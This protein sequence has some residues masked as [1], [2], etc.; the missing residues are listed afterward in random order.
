MLRPGRCLT[1]EPLQAD[2]DGWVHIDVP[3]DAE[4]A[5]IE[6]APSEVPVRDPYP[7]RAH[8]YLDLGNLGEQDRARRRLFNLG[9]SW[10][11]SLSDNVREYE[12]AHGLIP[13]TGDWK[14]IAEALEA[15]HDGGHPPKG[16]PAGDVILAI[17]GDVVQA[18]P[19]GD[20][21]DPP[22]DK[23]GGQGKRIRLPTV[24]EETLH[25]TWASIDVAIY[26]SADL[27]NL[28]HGAAG[29][30]PNVHYSPIP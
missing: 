1:P 12:M 24:L 23:S 10:H 29:I 22:G 7:Y 4:W 18:D 27:G 17:D 6:W 30:P 13:P 11:R 20:G 14:S 9:F 21:A 19:T 5:F 16:S 3:A 8:H 26:R 25:W 15:H 2:G 28:A